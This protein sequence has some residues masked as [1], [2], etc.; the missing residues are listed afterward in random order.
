ML[1]ILWL[2]LRT[3]LIVA[4]ILL[5]IALLFLLLVLFCPVRYRA[6]ASKKREDPIREVRAEGSV[7]WLLHALSFRF[8]YEH[9]K[10]RMSLKI[11]GIP[12]N[13]LLNREKPEKEKKK[14][15]NSD[16]HSKTE[17]QRK[18]GAERSGSEGR[19]RPPA[20]DDVSEKT[21][22]AAEDQQTGTKKIPEDKQGPGNKQIPED[23]GPG[24]TETSRNKEKSFFERCLE[25]I[26]KTIGKIKAFPERGKAELLRMRSTVEEQIKKAKWWM[27][28]VGDERTSEAAALLLEEGKS[29]IRHVFPK[30]IGGELCFDSE[31]PSVVGSV[32]ALYAMTIPFHE[33]RI[34]FKPGFQ[35]ENVLEGEIFLKGRVFLIRIAIAGIRLYFNKNIKYVMKTWRH[36]EDKTDEQ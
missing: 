1:H 10:T 13:R 2:I 12:M 23:R 9:G 22:S 4:G 8:F 27:D 26:K 35:C 25:R 3:I 21:G 29:L 36:K 11:L 14:R 6:A 5:G 17:R 24:K 30:K 28:F 31:D 20:P 18:T 15:K 32:V 33:N 7:T 19:K 16:R 34:S